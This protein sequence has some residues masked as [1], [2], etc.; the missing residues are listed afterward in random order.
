MS[1]DVKREL[2]RLARSDE[3]QGADPA[4]GSATSKVAPPYE[5]AGSVAPGTT[6]LW[7]DTSEPHRITRF[8]RREFNLIVATST[9]E[10]RRLLSNRADPVS[11]RDLRHR[12]PDRDNA[13]LDDLRA[14]REEG[15]YDG[16]RCSHVRPNRGPG[17]R[18]T[19]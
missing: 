2:P 11:T 15:L 17:R 1:N 16:R 5:Q 18:R 3:V 7:I 10:A 12:R 8:P 13:G 9:D 4:M 6:V 14:F 19:V